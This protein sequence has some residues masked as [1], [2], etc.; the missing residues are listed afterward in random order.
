VVHLTH[1]QT[2]ADLERQVE[3]GGVGGRHVGA[4]QRGVR[5]VVRDLLHRRVEE[6]GQED[7]TE[8]QDDEREQRDLA[9]Q[10]R[11]VIGEN[12]VEQATERG[13]DLQ[14]LVDTLGC[15]T[16]DGC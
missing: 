5:A 7:T 3:R 10:E 9:E 6:E 8:Q 4:A 12:L 2:T 16:R 1:E 13:G 15:G 14:T 11:P